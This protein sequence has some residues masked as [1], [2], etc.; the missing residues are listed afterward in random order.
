VIENNRRGGERARVG[1]R[2][3]KMSLS[4]WDCISLRVLEYECLDYFLHNSWRGFLYRDE[5]YE[6]IE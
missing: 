6:E 5:M 1:V 3:E 2:G 4:Y